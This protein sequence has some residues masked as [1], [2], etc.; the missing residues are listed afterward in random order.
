MDYEPTITTM[1][2]TQLHHYTIGLC[3]DK[4][5]TKTPGMAVFGLI[6][7]EFCQSDCMQPPHLYYFWKAWQL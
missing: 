7:L 1:P 5:P 6:S 2:M 4:L 3:R